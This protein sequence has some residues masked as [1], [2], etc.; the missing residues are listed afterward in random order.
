[1]L[2]IIADAKISIGVLFLQEHR[3]CAA[4][5]AGL[6]WQHPG[7]D[8]MGAPTVLLPANAMFL[9]HF[10]ILKKYYFHP[11][12]KTQGA[13]LSLSTQKSHHYFCVLNALV[14][15]N[16]VVSE[17]LSHEQRLQGLVFA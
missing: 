6:Q 16:L 9:L 7:L 4:A 15:A 13:S 12:L 1:M 5:Q 2:C 3:E 10:T 8:R 17:H 11:V 14:L